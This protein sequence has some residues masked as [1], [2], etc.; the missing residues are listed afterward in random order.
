MPDVRLGRD[1]VTELDMLELGWRVAIEF[2]YQLLVS[3][4]DYDAFILAI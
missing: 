4:G 1:L 2:P 3:G